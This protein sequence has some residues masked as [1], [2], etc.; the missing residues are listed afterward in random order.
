VAPLRVASYPHHFHPCL[1]FVGKV[2][3]YLSGAQGDPLKV[4]SKGTAT[5]V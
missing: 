5:I 2:A 1:I 3:V 4:H